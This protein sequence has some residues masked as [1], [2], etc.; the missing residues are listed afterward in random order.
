MNKNT[1]ME[2][3]L[4]CRNVFKFLR[5]MIRRHFSEGFGTTKSLGIADF[6]VPKLPLILP[7]PES[8]LVGIYFLVHP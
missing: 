1:L 3:L 4:Y 8:L 7:V 6:L 5:F 2:N